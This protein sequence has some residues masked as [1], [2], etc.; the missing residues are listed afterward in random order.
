MK[1]DSLIPSLIHVHVYSQ[2]CVKRP[3]KK[4]LYWLLLHESSAESFLH[5]FHSATE[6]PV[7][8]DF[9]ST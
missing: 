6:P 9:H 2:I 3:Y 1:A 8:S 5:Y 7:Y 4:D